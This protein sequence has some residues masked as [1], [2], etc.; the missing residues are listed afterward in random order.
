MKNINKLISL[1][2]AIQNYSKDI[3]YNCIG[4]EAYSWHLLADRIQENIS[5]YIDRIKEY[6]LGSDINPLSSKE[7]LEMAFA[8]IPDIE[9]DTILSFT[10][11]QNL[12]VST[13]SLIDETKLDKA[14][15]NLISEIADNLKNS[16][17]IINLVIS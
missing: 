7:Y 11:M 3:H 15:D 17:G 14:G 10:K 16:N 2:I 1:L 5:E 9:K 4:K 6:L 8:I 12:I 13:L